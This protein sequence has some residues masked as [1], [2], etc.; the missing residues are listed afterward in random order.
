MCMCVSLSLFLALSH[1]THKHI[2]H[3]VLVESVAARRSH[4]DFVLCSWKR[5]TVDP[6]VPQ[7]LTL[8][9]PVKHPPKLSSFNP[10]S[11]ASDVALCGW[12][13]GSSWVWRTDG[14]GAVICCNARWMFFKMV[15]LA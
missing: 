12:K 13:H 1:I 2:V 11:A 9:G 15:A 8:A 3:L 14:A 10:H 7:T 4:L 5:Q 6:V